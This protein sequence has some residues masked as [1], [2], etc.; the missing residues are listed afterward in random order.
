MQIL[1]FCMNQICDQESPVC[2][3]ILYNTLYTFR[4]GMDLE[5]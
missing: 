3:H 5:E 2:V 4:T 1:G